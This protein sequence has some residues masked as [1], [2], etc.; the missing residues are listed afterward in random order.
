MPQINQ[1]SAIFISQLF[2]LAVVFGVIYFVIARAMVPKIRGTVSVREAKVASDLQKAQAA[3]EE[4]DRTEA[5]WRDRLDAARGEAARLSNEAKQASA[6]EMEAKVRKAANKINLKIEA[7]EGKIRDAVAAARV[8]IEAVAAEATQ[9]MVGRLTGITI[10]KKE[11]AQ[12]VKEQ[13]HV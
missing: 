12:A 4:A 9:D 11:A 8:E 5:E 2:W 13:L 6:R 10:D 3:R 1:L 7:A